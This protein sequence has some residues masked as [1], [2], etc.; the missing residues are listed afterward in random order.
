MTSSS[1]SFLFQKVLFSS[2]TYQWQTHNFVS[3]LSISIWKS[4]NLLYF[5]RNWVPVMTQTVTWLPFFC[6]SVYSHCCNSCENHLFIFIGTWNLRV[7]GYLGGCPIQ[8]THLIEKKRRDP[9][10]EGVY[11][12]TFSFSGRTVDK[13]RVPN[14]QSRLGSHTKSPPA[15]TESGAPVK[16]FCSYPTYPNCVAQTNAQSIRHRTLL[17]QSHFR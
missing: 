1:K 9:W 11:L 6:P 14:A 8:A 13:T 5:L 7:T 15:L 2:K 17:G 16:A 10:R 3:F 4:Y 12:R